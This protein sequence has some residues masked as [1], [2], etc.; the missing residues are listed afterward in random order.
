[1]VSSVPFDILADPSGS[2]Q[3]LFDQH[4]QSTSSDEFSNVLSNRFKDIFGGDRLGL[5]SL[6]C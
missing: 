5:V 2:I 4:I 3:E 6:K 1:M